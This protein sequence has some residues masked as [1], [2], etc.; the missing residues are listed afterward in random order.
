M[1][2]K[3]QGKVLG[4]MLP[5]I[6]WLAA[7]IGVVSLYS[8]RHHTFAITGLAIA[9]TQMVSGGDNGVIRHLPVEL[10][11][12]VQRGDL[13]AIIELGSPPE[14]DYARALIEAQR[15]TAVAELDR[16]GTE[17]SAI[18]A[19]LRYDFQID[20]GDQAMRYQR[21]AL[22]VEQAQLNLL[23]I[24]TTLE[25]DRG[26]LASLELE[27]NASRELLDRQ[28]IHLYEL[29]KAELEYAALARKIAAAEAL[30]RQARENLDAA[31]QRLAQYS[32]SAQ[33]EQLVDT[34]LEPYRKAV[35]VQEKILHG[36]F[37]PPGR[38]MINAQ[39]DGVVSAIFMSEGQGFQAGEWILQV[40]APSADYVV[41]WLDPIRANQIQ[42]NQSVEIAKHS[43]PQQ[44]FQ[45]EIAI[46][47]PA[48]ELLPEQLWAAP[49]SPRWGRPVKIPVPQGSQLS[50]NEVVGI[51]GL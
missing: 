15:A 8:Y 24:R 11:Q 17:L 13:L 26:L 5:V 38:M 29:Q 21:L 19:Q 47:G 40:S 44:R 10:F 50:G 42:P 45:S 23:E 30:E 1:A 18:E 31:Q 6:V 48:V 7:V 2:R 32:P 36:L 34:L 41:A 16:L 3:R 4:G 28:A 33:E 43:I 35:T 37:A 25:L 39:I 46:I 9:R 27:K 22:E 12:T 20:A 14:N 51:R 49:T